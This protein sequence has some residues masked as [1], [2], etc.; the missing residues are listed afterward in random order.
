MCIWH[1][2]HCGPIK[3]WFLHRIHHALIH[4]SSSSLFAWV[5]FDTRFSNSVTL[6]LLSN[7][8]DKKTAKEPDDSSRFKNRS[9]H[10]SCFRVYVQVLIQKR[11]IHR[12]EKELARKSLLVLSPVH[13]H[14]CV[15]FSNCCD[16]NRDSFVLTP[17]IHFLTTTDHSRSFFSGEKKSCVL[18]VTSIFNLIYFFLSLF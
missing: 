8:L 9:N 7:V 16:V 6:S 10:N 4:F 14:V 11:E 13:V 2:R 15:H 5:W 1:T 3:D 18:Q 17:Y 12:P